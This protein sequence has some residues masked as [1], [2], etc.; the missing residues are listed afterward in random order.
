M[1]LYSNTIEK[2]RSSNFVSP[3]INEENQEEKLNVKELNFDIDIFKENCMGKPYETIEEIEFAFI[4]LSRLKNINIF[5]NIRELTIIGCPIKSLNGLEG[6]NNSLE[7]LF[8]I[9]C[10]LTGIEKTL[11]KLKNL[12]TLSFGENLIK[13]IRNLHKY[14]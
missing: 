12:K 14:E 3:Y 7:S 6:V 4:K 1:E 10:E 5:T 11:T 13:E 9:G 8:M 2:P